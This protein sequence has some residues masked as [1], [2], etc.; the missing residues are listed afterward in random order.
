MLRHFSILIY[1]GCHLG[2]FEALLEPPS[3]IFDAPTAGAPPRPGPAEGWFNSGIAPKP[4]NL[5]SFWLK[6]GDT[7]CGVA[8]PQNDQALCSSEVHEQ[9][10]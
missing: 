2:L 5:Y 8:A 7:E 1:L 6:A 3:G 10:T 9:E 4:D